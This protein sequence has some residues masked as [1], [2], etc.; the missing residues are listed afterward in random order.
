MRHKYILLLLFSVFS[1]LL[2]AQDNTVELSVK[3][4]NNMALGNFVALSIDANT[5]PCKSFSLK[6]GLQY[7]FSSDFVAEVRPAYF[8][9]LPKM[10]LSVEA[11]V[12]YQP[13]NNIHNVAAGGGF[14]LRTRYLW[15]TL[16]YYHRSITSGKSRFCEPFNLYYEFGV[17]VLPSVEICDLMFSISN[18]RIF[19]LERHYQPSLIVD[20]MLYP[21]EKWGVVLGACYKP[22]GMFNLSSDYYQFYANIGVCY[23]W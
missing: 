3:G 2:Y 13:L 7:N 4:G 8:Y 20:C 6:G 18:S 15:A 1:S 17:N 14:G 11:L 22:A 16:G 19:D 9:D 12:H 23:K 10:R 5:V 21:I